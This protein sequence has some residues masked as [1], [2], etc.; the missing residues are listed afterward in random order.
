MAND[1]SLKKREWM[2][3]FVVLSSIFA[4]ALVSQVKKRNIEGICVQKNLS[5]CERYKKKNIFSRFDCLKI[6]DFAI[7]FRMSL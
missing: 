6:E 2:I 7:L 3:I 1:F 5:K 4:C